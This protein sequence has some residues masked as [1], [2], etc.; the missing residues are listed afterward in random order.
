MQTQ[1]PPASGRVLPPSMLTPFPRF[2]PL[3]DGALLLHR[4]PGG[5]DPLSALRPERALLH[6][7]HLTHPP[8]RGH[9]R[10]PSP[11]RLAWWV[12][13]GCFQ[14]SSGCCEGRG[15]LCL[16][17]AELLGSCLA[18]HGCR[19]LGVCVP[20]GSSLAR[21]C[22]QNNRDTEV[23]W[24]SGSRM[25]CHSSGAKGSMG[26]SLPLVPFPGARSP[27]KMEK[28]AIQRQADHCNDRKM[29]SKRVQELSADLFF[30]IFVRVRAKTVFP[31]G[32]FGF[33]HEGSA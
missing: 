6:A 19:V 28:E 32:I 20:Q 16:A 26:T 13:P 10:A 15:W 4:C 29:A 2:S 25:P 23:N 30:A 1:T 5:R 12:L 9:H 31:R 24:T 33:P 22:P 3:S 7:L 21:G 27:I 17:Q 14:S 8:L 18:C 11:L